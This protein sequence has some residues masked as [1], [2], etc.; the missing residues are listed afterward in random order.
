AAAVAG[1]I[2][3]AVVG[4]GGMGAAL[5]VGAVKLAVGFGAVSLLGGLIDTVSSKVSAMVDSA[6]PAFGPVASGSG[7]V[8]VEKQPVARATK[9]TVACT[10]HNSP[11]LIAQGSESVFV[12]DAPAARID[13]KTVCGATLKEGASTVFFGSGQGTYLDIADEFSWWEKALLIAVEFLVP[14]SRG[15]FRGLG[16]LFTRGPMAVLKGMRA[17]AVTVMRGLK[18]AVSCASKGFRNNRGLTRVTEA[19]R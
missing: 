1:A 16:K 8:F 3:V 14:P 18:E 19:V 5:V 2:A 4:T 10:R 13:D 12:N 15:M 9:D 6:S 17:G 7:N 11:Q